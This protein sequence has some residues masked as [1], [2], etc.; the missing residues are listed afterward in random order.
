MN[1]PHCKKKIKD[2][3]IKAEAARLSSA[4]QE[5]FGAG[6]GRPRSTERCPCGA[7]TLQHA[8]A[9]KHVCTS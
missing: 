9:R 4:M 2:A 1:C 5:N 7:M 8:A 6:T 3:L